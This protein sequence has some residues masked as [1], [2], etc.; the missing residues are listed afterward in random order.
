MAAFILCALRRRAVA[1][2]FALGRNTR[3]HWAWWAVDL[4]CG[5]GLRRPACAGRLR[6]VAAL[7]S[8][9][10]LEELG[11]SGTAFPGDRRKP[12]IDAAGQ[13]YRGQWIGLTSILLPLTATG[14]GGAPTAAS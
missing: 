13:V 11:Y 8:A 7:L 10:A 9:P 14:G 4:D 12:V 1:A 3:R 2:A 6:S 5:V